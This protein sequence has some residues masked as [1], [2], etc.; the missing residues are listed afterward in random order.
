M[1]LKSIKDI[2]RFQQAI[3][4]CKDNVWLR[5]IN[6]EAYNLKSALSQYVGIAKVVSGRK[7]DTF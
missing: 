3:A 6:G 2:E 1:T 7:E 4:K 5:S